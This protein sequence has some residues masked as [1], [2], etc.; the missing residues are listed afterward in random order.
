MTFKEW[1]AVIQV[2][3]GV[4]VGVWLWRD[5]EGVMPATIELAAQRTLWAL[6]GVIVLNI[7]ASIVI[8][9]LVSIAQGEELKDERSDERDHSVNSRGMRNAYIVA[10]I[11]GL[12][13]LIYLALGGNPPG[14]AYGIFGVLMLAGMTDAVSRLVYYRI[15]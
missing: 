6:G 14:A 7:V 3:T 12:G 11:G 8:A 15:G 1:T 5:A 13:V 4:V 2:G 9:I 10:S